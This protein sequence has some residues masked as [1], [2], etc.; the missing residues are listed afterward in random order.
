MKDYRRILRKVGWVLVAI[1]LIDIAY[2]IYCVTHETSYSSSVN[3]FAV[4]AGVFLLCGNL[5]TARLISFFTAFCIAGFVGGMIVLPFLL[6]L[7]LLL[8]YIRLATIDAVA[9][10]ILMLVIMTLLIWVY[11]NLTSKSVRAA[12]DEAWVDYTSFW[13]KPTRG[14]WIGGCLALLAAVLL[15]LLTGGATATEAKQRA[16]AQVGSGYKFC[17]ISMNVSAR[18]GGRQVYAVVTAYNDREIKSVPVRWSE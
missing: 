12:M 3:I 16:A 13:H 2:M 6:P 10:I 17:V 1:G 14:F 5:K 8:S 9:I 15:P 4:I 7:D 11:R 18:T